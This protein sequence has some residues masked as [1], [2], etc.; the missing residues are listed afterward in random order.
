MNPV[1]IDPTYTVLCDYFCVDKRAVRI[2]PITTESIESGDRQADAG[3]H[4]RYGGPQEGEV[5]VRLVIFSG[6]RDP[7]WTLKPEEIEEL[8]AKISAMPEPPARPP[9]Y[10]YLGYRGFRVWNR[11]DPEL[12]AEFMVFGGVLTIINRQSE[13]AEP[14]LAYRQD[15]EQAVERVLLHAALRQRRDE[16][17]AEGAAEEGAAEGEA[18]EIDLF[19]EGRAI[20]DQYE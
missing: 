19:P 15:T 9:S 20:L 3:A 8:K 17:A 16:A 10:P 5:T 11:R 18:D 12:P 14:Q 7:V 1:G 2:E 4:A 13:T 6:R